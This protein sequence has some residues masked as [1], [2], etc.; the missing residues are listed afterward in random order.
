MD[1]LP[2]RYPSAMILL[3][4]WDPP[5]HTGDFSAPALT[6]LVSEIKK[7][8]LTASICH[9]RVHYYYATKESLQE[10]D[11]KE[12]DMRYPLK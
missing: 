7:K 1:C 5:N 6:K 10:Y 2:I 11:T 9:I 12:P 4:S 8:L 3:H